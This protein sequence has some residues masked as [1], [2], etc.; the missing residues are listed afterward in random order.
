MYYTSG[1]RPPPLPL[2]VVHTRG[3]MVG[4]VLD[5]FL[6]EASYFLFCVKYA[7]KER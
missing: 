3:W 6:M 1:E 5:F 7:G 2:P 4:E